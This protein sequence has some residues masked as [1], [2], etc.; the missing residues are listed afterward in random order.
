[1]SYVRRAF[2]DTIY[3]LVPEGSDL[4]KIEAPVSADFYTVPEGW[5]ATP[6]TPRY[7][8]MLLQCGLTL[9]GRGKWTKPY[10][11]HYIVE[12]PAETIEALAARVAALESAI[13][14][15]DNYLARTAQPQ[16]VEP[17]AGAMEEQIEALIK[18]QKDKF[19]QRIEATMQAAINAAIQSEKTKTEEASSVPGTTYILKSSDGK[20]RVVL[21]MDDFMKL[22]E[23]RQNPIK[24]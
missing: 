16:T 8:E 20:E 13:V 11:S 7:G 10:C 15:L 22:A 9:N 18:E 3:K 4:S 24:E 6:T 12:K 2:I 1:M 23:K 14:L 17:S 5:S 19:K 21:S